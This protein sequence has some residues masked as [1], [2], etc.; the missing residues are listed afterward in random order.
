[1]VCRMCSYYWQEEGE[2]YPCC[3]WNLRCPGDIPPC[4][5]E[6]LETENLYEN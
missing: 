2:N 3:H 1:M 4:E 5:E 6:E